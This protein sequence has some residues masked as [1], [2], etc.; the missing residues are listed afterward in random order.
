MSEF[1]QT[2]SKDMAHISS[3]ASMADENFQNEM[4][5]EVHR[6]GDNANDLNNAIC[7]YEDDCNEVIEASEGNKQKCA[8]D[9]SNVDIFSSLEG[10]TAKTIEELEQLYTSHARVTG[11]GIKKYTQRTTKDVV[12]ERYYVCSCQGKKKEV[13][14]NETPADQQSLHR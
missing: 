6:D 5:D 7:L 14:S 8:T 12:V 10:I 1:D 3:M 2:Y 9:L 13:R 4:E 11:F